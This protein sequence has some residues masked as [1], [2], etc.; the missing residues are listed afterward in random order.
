MQAA[1][2][3]VNRER[4]KQRRDKVG[5]GKARQRQDETTRV[6]VWYDLG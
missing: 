4:A 2:L 1:T 6:V 5:Q 3:L